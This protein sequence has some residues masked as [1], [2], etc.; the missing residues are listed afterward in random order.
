[1][2]SQMPI[3]PAVAGK[4][5]RCLQCGAKNSPTAEMCR[6][7]GMSTPQAAEIRRRGVGG[8]G[9]V[10]KET[11]EREREA[12]RDYSAGRMSA[13]ARS[14]RPAELPLLPPNAWDDPAGYVATLP[15]SSSVAPSR[16]GRGFLFRRGTRQ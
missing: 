12:W 3:P 13:Q 2:P 14:R 15:D 1:M 5:I 7:C 10:F 9:I 4:G 6:I 11:V 8:E 16:K